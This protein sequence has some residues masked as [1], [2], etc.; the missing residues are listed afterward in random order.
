MNLESINM[1]NEI[2]L[3]AG[4]VVVLKTGGPKMTI[5]SIG[6][7]FAFC[8]WFDGTTL[9]EHTFKIEELRKSGSEN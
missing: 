8:Q 9:C 1:T 2:E 7:G 5:S 4:D 6:A 3:K